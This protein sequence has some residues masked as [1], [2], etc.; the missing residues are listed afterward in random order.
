MLLEFYSTLPKVGRLQ[1]NSKNMSIHKKELDSIIKY[2]LMHDSTKYEYAKYLRLLEQHQKELNQLYGS[3]KSNQER[4][5]YNDQLNRSYSKIGNEILQNYK[6]Y[7]AMDFMDNEKE[8]LKKHINELNFRSRNDYAK[9]ETKKNI[10]KDLYKICMLSGLND[11]QTKKVFERWIKNSN[12]NFDVDTLISTV[13]M[14]DTEMSIKEYYDALKK[15][16]YDSNRFNRFKNKYFY[17][18]LNYKRFI[19]QAVNH[20]MYEL[21]QEEKQI[22]NELQY[23]IS[24]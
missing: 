8:F 12:Y 11:S 7:Q 2:I 19:N 17:C 14:L 23:E 21:D 4:K 3:S 5:Y 16:G 18:E 9:D 6:R 24:S 1:Y 15:L 22:I 10:A 20:L 13:T